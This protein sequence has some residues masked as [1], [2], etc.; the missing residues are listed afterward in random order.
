MQQL[1]IDAIIKLKFRRDSTIIRLK[2]LLAIKVIKLELVKAVMEVKGVK[3][4]EVNDFE[5]IEATSYI[6]AA[7]YDDLVKFVSFQE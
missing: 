7:K 6:I 3:T 1:V 4:I 2:T 5:L